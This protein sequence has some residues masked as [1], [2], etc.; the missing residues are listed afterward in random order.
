MNCHLFFHHQF[1]VVITRICCSLLF[2]S[3][4]SALHTSCRKCSCLSKCHFLHSHQ[5]QMTVFISQEGH[6]FQAV[7]SGSADRHIIYD[8][9][10]WRARGSDMQ[11]TFRR[12]PSEGKPIQLTDSWLNSKSWCH[13][14]LCCH[15]KNGLWV[16][17]SG[18]KHDSSSMF[19]ISVR[20]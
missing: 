2:A 12:E 13:E 4:P 15:I 5:W 11:C 20:F 10:Q 9:R 16:V 18:Y 6:I 1:I 7:V 17:S 19:S 3:T 8:G 14:L